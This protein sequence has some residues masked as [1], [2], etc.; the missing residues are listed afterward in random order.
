MRSSTRPAEP[1][2]GLHAWRPRFACT[3]HASQL[4]A[5]AYC[6]H[7]DRAATACCTRNAPECIRS[8]G[9]VQSLRLHTAGRASDFMELAPG[10][11]RPRPG[12]SNPAFPPC[13]RIRLRSAHIPV[14]PPRRSSTG[15]VASRRAGRPLAAGWPFALGVGL[16]TCLSL[17]GSSSSSL[18]LRGSSPTS[19]WSA[20]FPPPRR[21]WSPP[22]S[23]CWTF[24]FRQSARPPSVRASVP[25]QCTG[26]TLY[27]HCLRTGTVPSTCTVHMCPCKNRA[28]VHVH[29]MTI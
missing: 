16:A 24:A 2:L 8:A 9:T 12:S 11:V 21:G 23:G 22:R 15:I 28:H 7:G 18:H 19:C 13:L 5:H 25:V 26:H 4:V 27:G 20:G 29:L 17:C 6:L 3:V 10:A 14:T 1:P